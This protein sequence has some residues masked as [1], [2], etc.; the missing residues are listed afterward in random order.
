MSRKFKLLDF[1]HNECDAAKEPEK[2]VDNWLNSSGNPCSICDK[3][4]S[5][6]KLYQKLVEIGALDNKDRLERRSKER[7]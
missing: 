1:V 5:K 6:C 2:F 3:D 4:K 7:H